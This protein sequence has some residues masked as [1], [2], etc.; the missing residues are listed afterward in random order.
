MSGL[1]IFSQ[2]IKKQ[3]ESM[4]IVFPLLLPTFHTTSLLH[5]GFYI[6]VQYCKHYDSG[7]KQNKIFA[8][9]LYKTS[10]FFSSLILYYLLVLHQQVDSPC[11]F[12]PDCKFYHS[13]QSIFLSTTVPLCTSNRPAVQPAGSR[14]IGS[15]AACSGCCRPCLCAKFL[16]KSTNYLKKS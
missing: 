14:V 3:S 5:L 8:N 6:S 13:V 12:F 1:L 11:C 10:I 2:N 7:G 15:D 16:I 9:M 4:E